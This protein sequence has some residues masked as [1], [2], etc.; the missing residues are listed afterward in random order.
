MISAILKKFAG[1]HHRRFVKRCGPIVAKINK[2]EQELQKLS[3][4]ELRAKTDTLKE[5]YQVGMDKAREHMGNHVDGDKLY[6][7]SEALLKQMLPEAFAVVKNAARRLCCQEIEFSGMHDV[8]NMVPYDV[9]LMGGIALH[10][11]NISEMATG[12][13]KTLVATMPLY[14]N[15][16]TGKN[17][18]Q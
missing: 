5:F 4:E 7:A 14:L 17:C 1:S 10:Q 6:D 8:W 2:I 3:D 18:Q 13:G 16:L 12:E 9:Q 11:G 15:A